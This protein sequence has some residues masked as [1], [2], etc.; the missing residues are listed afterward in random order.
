M[1]RYDYK[2]T[3]CGYITEL[4]HSMNEDTLPEC[5]D[6]MT[7]L[8]KVISAVASHFKG[9]GWGKTYRVHKPKDIK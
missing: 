1:P 8:K 7:P 6:C 3:T 2:C 9:Q 5:P 4:E